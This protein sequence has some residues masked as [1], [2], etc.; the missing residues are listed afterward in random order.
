MIEYTREPDPQLGIIF[1]YFT[2]GQLISI[3]FFI[4]GLFIYFKKNES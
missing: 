3:I 2:L 1:A 4:F